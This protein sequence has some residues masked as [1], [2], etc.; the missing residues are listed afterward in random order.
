MRSFINRR[1]FIIIGP[2]GTIKKINELGFKTF[3]SIFDEGYDT[4]SD[5]SERITKIVDVINKISNLSLE[6]LRQLLKD[7]EPILEHNYRYYH[8]NFGKSDLEKALQNL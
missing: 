4:V 8:N 7:I 2:C 6:E 5:P 1:P 3:S